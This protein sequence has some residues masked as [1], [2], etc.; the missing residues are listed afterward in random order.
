MYIPS[1]Y[2]ESILG[3]IQDYASFGATLTMLDEGDF[4]VDCDVRN[5]LPKISFLFGGYW[6]EMLPED[7]IVE[8]EG[9]CFGCLG[10]G[11]F[12]AYTQ[13][14]LLGDAFLRGF[15]STHDHEN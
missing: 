10:A 8:Y 14:W 9:F 2:Y 15:Y 4:I 6:M 3:L 5:Y 1:Y 12:S 13:E 7:Y 11:D